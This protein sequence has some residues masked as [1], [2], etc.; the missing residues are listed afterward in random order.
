[1]KGTLN[2]GYALLRE[3]RL[4][5]RYR[6]RRRT[7]EVLEEMENFS[8]SPQ[9]ILDL[10][11]AEGRMLEKIKC[12]YPFSLCIGIDY[13][14]EL[15]NYGAK[16][17]PEINFICAD[18]QNLGFLKGEIFDVLIATAV[19]EHLRFPERMLKE[20][21]RLL[22]KGGIIII[23]S[24]HPFWEKIADILG[25]IKGGHKGGHQSV[26]NPEK[27]SVLCK[28]VGFYILEQKGFMISPV[29]MMGE[30]RIEKILA[31]I[32][33]DKFLPNQLIVAK[34]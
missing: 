20:S 34:R 31:R 14:W 19:I 33:L 13:S 2:L 12:R 28:K 24:P 22:K 23:T 30:L 1:M 32:G 18:V 9:R 8:S 10:G 26:M 7:H 15:L 11:T 16:R 27:L 21:L 6:L 29:G 4:D 3:K 5:L 25:L 17:L